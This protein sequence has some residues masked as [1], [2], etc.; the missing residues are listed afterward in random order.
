MIGEIEK[1][2]HSLAETSK[3]HIMDKDFIGRTEDV[4]LEIL[5]EVLAEKIEE[6]GFLNL[7]LEKEFR[8]V[9]IYNEIVRELDIILNTAHEIAS[10]KTWSIHVTHEPLEDIIREIIKELIDK[11]GFEDLWVKPKVESSQFYIE[12]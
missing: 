10:R 9:E 1:L 6:M 11:S 5:E 8:L 7:R 2:A 3:N 4:L 12:I